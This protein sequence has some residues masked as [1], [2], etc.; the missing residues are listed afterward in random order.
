VT[1]KAAKKAPYESRPARLSKNRFYWVTLHKNLDVVLNK[2][3]E[4]DEATTKK[5]PGPS[6]Y[7]SFERNT[8]Y[9]P[10]KFT[11]PLTNWTAEEVEIFRQFMNEAL[12]LTLEVVKERDAEAQRKLEEEDDDSW[13]RLYRPV[14]KIFRKKGAGRQ[15]RTFISQR[16][17]WA[18]TVDEE[19]DDSDG[20]V[21]ES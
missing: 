20:S 7:I 6:F 15:H 8:K 16:P 5:E 9:R 10:T 14:P 18:S 11:I 2:A 3:V 21:S 17:D 19:A 4:D 13:S 12:D 1:D